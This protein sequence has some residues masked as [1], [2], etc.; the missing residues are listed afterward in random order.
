[1]TNYGRGNPK[2]MRITLGAMASGAILVTTYCVAPDRT[3][4][5]GEINS[6][7]GP[8]ERASAWVDIDSPADVERVVSMLGQAIRESHA[9]INGGRPSSA[10]FEES[11]CAAF[12]AIVSRDGAKY[13][14]HALDRGWV[15]NRDMA[16]ALAAQWHE[17]GV[18]P[19]ALSDDIADR[20]IFAA[21]WNSAAQRGMRVT[22]VD[23]AN[24]SV[25]RG[26]LLVIDRDNWPYPGARGQV[27]CFMS[28]RG[29][30]TQ[31]EGA[32]ID[33]TPH[34]AHVLIR[35]RFEN[36]SFGHVRLNYFHDL[37]S[38]MWVPL[39]IAVGTESDQEWPWPLF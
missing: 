4:V 19:E 17:W 36:G 28:P 26:I 39:T 5:P 35:I 23:G 33:R 20:A 21:L 2:L 25:G 34:S 15:F 14:R 6:T 24:F 8:H 7:E 32:A 16:L 9:S 1:M 13:W 11:A 3:S 38:E 37:T 10:G 31:E 30:L 29:R 27:S 12:E 18:L 22:A